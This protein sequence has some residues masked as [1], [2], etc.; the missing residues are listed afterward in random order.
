M[1]FWLGGLNGDPFDPDDHPESGDEFG[2]DDMPSILRS[3][4]RRHPSIY[5][6]RTGL[7]DINNG[8]GYW[9]TKDGVIL[10]IKNMETTHLIN[11]VALIW[12]VTAKSRRALRDNPPSHIKNV[13]PIQLQVDDPEAKIDEM[14]EELE[15]RD[16]NPTFVRIR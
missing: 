12:R 16:I 13:D 3:F 2:P 9:T 8:P 4:R 7:S 15:K 6:Y 1:T 11:T 10:K 5:G 14:L